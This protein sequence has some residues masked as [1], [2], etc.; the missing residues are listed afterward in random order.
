[1][2]FFH[3]RSQLVGHRHSLV[4]LFSAALFQSVVQL[5]L[6]L[7]H[8]RQN[9]LSAPS[10]PLKARSRNTLP[11]GKLRKTK[12]Q[13]TDISKGK[14]HIRSSS[15]PGCWG[16]PWQPLLL[17]QTPGGPI[18]PACP[19]APR[20]PGGPGVPSSPLEPGGPSLDSPGGPE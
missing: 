11:R 5:Q 6:K 1:M 3:V 10:R 20:P 7:N 14:A 17:S 13:S 12:Q 2:S 15:S 16:T 19:E 18:S 4:V 9:R 8:F